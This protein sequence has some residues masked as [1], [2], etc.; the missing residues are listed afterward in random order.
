M[1]APPPSL[2]VFS[3]DIV[4]PQP[5]LGAAGSIIFV[6]RLVSPSGM[7]FP[8]YLRFGLTDC[9]RTFVA[10]ASCDKD[11]MIRLCGQKV[12]GRQAETFRARR[13][14][15]GSFDGTSYTEH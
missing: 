11:E 13:C 5:P 8:Q 3:E 4:M 6:C 2:D 10:S 12:T 9:L 15:S 7:M 1:S 14:A